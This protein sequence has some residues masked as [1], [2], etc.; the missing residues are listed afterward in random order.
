MGPFFFNFFTK[1]CFFKK[2]IENTIKITNFIKTNF[3]NGLFLAPWG[4]L[5]ASW[6]AL[7]GPKNIKNNR[8]SGFSCFGRSG[9]PLGSSSGPLGPSW[10]VFGPLLAVFGWSGLV[11]L[12]V[13]SS[14]LSCLSG[15]SCLVWVWVWVWSG[16]LRVSVWPLVAVLGRLVFFSP[17]GPSWVFLSFLGLVRPPSGPVSLRKTECFW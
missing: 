16:L 8:N 12:S 13:F 7:G 5:G 2:I 4:L 9:G 15:L 17:F 1:A 3:E 14:C 6:G 11:C 10:A